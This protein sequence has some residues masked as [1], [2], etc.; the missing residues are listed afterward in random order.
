MFYNCS[1]LE[2][3]EILDKKYTKVETL[4]KI[5]SEDDLVEDFDAKKNEFDDFVEDDKS[6]SIYEDLEYCQSLT[7][8]QNYRSHSIRR[9]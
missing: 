3:I 1:M 8:S 2:K 6:N 9:K 5:N 4:S 7:N